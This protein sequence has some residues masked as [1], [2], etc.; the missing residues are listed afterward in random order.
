MQSILTPGKRQGD[1]LGLLEEAQRKFG[2]VPQEFMAGLA[3]SLG[4][5]LSDIYG[6]AT[7]YSFLATKPQGRNVIRICRSLPCWLKNAEIIV[8]SVAQELGI[9]PGETTA[10]RKFSFELTNCIGACDIAPAML[11]NS[12]VHGELTPG[13]IA[14]ILKSYK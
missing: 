2:Y 13:K 10:D 8:N 5:P 3:Q 6:V 11:I 4:I 1:L 14:R 7:F 12:D 9:N